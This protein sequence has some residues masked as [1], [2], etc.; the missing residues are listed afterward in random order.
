MSWSNKY[1]KVLIAIIPKDLAKKLIVQVKRKE[2][3][4]L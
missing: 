2:M 4:I 1:K 3:R